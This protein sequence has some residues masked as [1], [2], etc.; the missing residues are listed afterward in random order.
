MS[1]QRL[2][3]FSSTE[4]AERDID[5]LLDLPQYRRWSFSKFVRECIHNEAARIKKQTLKQQRGA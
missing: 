2:R 3:A 1:P 4:E 5:F